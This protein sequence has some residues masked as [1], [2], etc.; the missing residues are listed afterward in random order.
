MLTFRTAQ[1]LFN[2]FKTAV[3]ESNTQLTE[4]RRAI[5]SEKSQKVFKLALRESAGES[6]RHQA[7]AS[8]GTIP[9]G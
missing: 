2:S 4:F 9:T 1:M 5:T 3:Q 8:Q 6:Q 7:V